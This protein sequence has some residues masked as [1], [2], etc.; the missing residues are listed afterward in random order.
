MAVDQR[1]VVAAAKF[2]VSSGKVN[3][4]DLSVTQCFDTSLF[5]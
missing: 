4:K 3:L 2:S 5:C 1:Q